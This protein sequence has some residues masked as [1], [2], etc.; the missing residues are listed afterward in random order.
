MSF[1]GRNYLMMFDPKHIQ[2]HIGTDLVYNDNL[3]LLI[4]VE[5]YFKELCTNEG[6]ECSHDCTAYENPYF[7]TLNYS[8][9]CGMFIMHPLQF[10]LS[11]FQTYDA[12]NDNKKSI[13]H[14]DW[15][16][17][18]ITRKN[19]SKYTNK[20]EESINL[21][22]IKQAKSL[23]VLPGGNKF[24]FQINKNKLAR[25]CRNYGKNL[26][27]KPH[28]ISEDKFIDTLK[29]YGIKSIL[30]NKNVDLY[31]LM[32][33]VDKVYTTH[34]SETALTAQVLGKKIEPI[35][36]ADKRLFGSFSHINHFL[37]TEEYP[38]S[39]IDSIFA[40]PKSGIIQPEIDKD[41]KNKMEQYFEYILKKRDIQR[42]YYD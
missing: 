22:L 37:F 35:D 1:V 30:V 26:L 32:N 42:G 38:L 36:K 29:M 21:D 20:K 34:I 4:P 10:E 25:L 24:E 6:I 23:I 39:V 11:W 41:W 7:K 19:I 8:S 18:K 15:I 13:G 16:K 33:S 27:I 12:K 40:S 31:L 3:N 28:P 5:I 9:F 2:K 14:L 17:D